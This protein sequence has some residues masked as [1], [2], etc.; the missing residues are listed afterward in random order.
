MNDTGLFSAM[1]EVSPKVQLQLEKKC[2]E[3]V[4]I[5]DH[6]AAFFYDPILELDSPFSF[7]QIDEIDTLKEYFSYGNWSIRC[8]VVYKDLAFIQQVGGGDDWWTLKR[9]GDGF[10]AIEDISFLPVIKAGNFE[11]LIDRLETDSVEQ[12]NQTNINDPSAGPILKL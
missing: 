6:G 11:S 10:V 1:K 2:Q 8:G 12:H 9:D 7:S 3:N 4:W 5:K